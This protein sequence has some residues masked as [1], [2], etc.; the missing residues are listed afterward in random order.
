MKAHLRPG[1]S[2]VKVLACLLTAL[3]LLCCAGCG[4]RPSSTGTAPS[5]VHS[6]TPPAKVEPASDPDLA[7]IPV[8]PLDALSPESFPS[9][10]ALGA[11]QVLACWAEYGD[12]T[13]ESNTCCAIVD[14]VQDQ[15]IRSATLKGALSLQ[16]TFSD[17]TALLFS[18]EREQFYLLDEALHAAPLSV[19]V[20]GGQFSH[21]HSRYYYTQDELLYEY[22]PETHHQSPVPLEEGIRISSI[23]AIHPSLDYLMVWVY[24]SL[25]SLD[26]C[27]ALI[28]C[29]TG[30]LLL[31][32]D[33]LSS[34]G[35]Y[36]E[37]FQS[38]FFDD[39]GTQDL[40]VWGELTSDSPLCCVSL[41]TLEDAY[42]T[43]QPLADSNYALQVYDDSWGPQQDQ[44][45]G[46]STALFRLE[47]D[48]LSRCQLTDYAL[49]EALIGALYL[50]EEDLIL[51]YT[52][53]Q[54]G[55]QLYLIN[56]GALEYSHVDL[57]LQEAPQRIDQQRWE[58]CLAE[59]DSPELSPDLKGVQA[60]AD[61]LEDRFDVHILLSAEC[62]DPCE[63]SGYD[64]TTSDQAGWR[65]EAL[66]ISRAL[67]QLEQALA[68]YPDGFFSQFRT[69]SQDSGIYLMLV[70]AISSDDP[71][72]VAA[73]E[74]G[75]GAR[76]YIG[77]DISFYEL[78]GNLYHELWHAT[79]NKIL[80]SSF[81]GFYD[82][83]WDACNPEGFAYRYAYNLSDQN[84][85]LWQGT[86]TGGDQEFYFVDD[87][88]KTYP[89]EDRARIME[90]VMGDDALAQAVLRSPAIRQKLQLMD[91]GIR[92]AF[93]TSG[94]EDVHWM[95]FG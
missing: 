70:G 11:D 28:D 50:P 12:G 93:N 81:S 16:R 71:I 48:G 42:T 9:F 37:H 58:N 61:E 80:R 6:T 32:Q 64:V 88:S 13:E 21:D 27:S 82:G 34:P 59:L 22:N 38:R 90:Y 36:G 92:T 8:A 67:K 86:Y 1:L 87:Y 69:E 62:A 46:P 45:E 85:T 25:Y 17:G 29:E 47:E 78:R 18:Y 49:E 41:D 60:K 3:V 26:T 35:F 79:E 7:G 72:N 94:W 55:Y 2:S 77:L 74:F 83:S 51:G 31:L 66:T 4:Q 5:P 20:P 23:S 52:Y 15:V 44:S 43:F 95:R 33:G 56:P 19:P 54:A 39:N 89:K 57:P 84:G 65:N 76:E 24:P 63:A 30:Q 40:L 68:N 75:L 73:F 91:Q 10:G 53:R 14:V